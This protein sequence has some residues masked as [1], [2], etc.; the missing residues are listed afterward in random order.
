MFIDLEEQYDKIYRYCYMKTQHQQTAEDITQETFLRFLE[1]YTYKEMG[2]RMAYLYTIARNLCIDS[3]RRKK[4][5]PLNEKIVQKERFVK[6]N[7]EGMIVQNIDLKAALGRLEPEEQELIFWR[8]VNELPIQQIG[9]I[10]GISRFAVY[11]RTRESLN[12]LRQDLGEE[13]SL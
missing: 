8:Y 13:E 4:A 5:V 11:R 6:E 2:K 12:K 1:D 9:R 3:F 7:T 10:L